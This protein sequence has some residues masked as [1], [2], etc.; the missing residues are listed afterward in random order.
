MRY[1]IY[2]ELGHL[3]AYRLASKNSKTA[4]A[5]VVKFEIGQINN[6]TT[7]WKPYYHFNA[8]NNDEKIVEN[9][10]KIE[11]TL[12]WFIAVTA[13]CTMQS[14]FEQKSFRSCFQIG[15]VGGSDF[16]QI[17]MILYTVKY[18]LSSSIKW[19]D[20]Y[21]LQREF[22]NIVKNHHV[23]N[24][25]EAIVEDI[26]TDITNSD[27]NQ[28]CLENQDLDELI[29]RVDKLITPEIIDDYLYLINK[30]K[31]NLNVEYSE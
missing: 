2:H 4:L 27:E 29:K 30:F 26:E 24:K 5:E 19:K 15:R 13:G 7:T 28:I 8:S 21:G 18:W 23:I 12:A 10:L 16:S 20:I 6:R 25:L 3:F 17:K 14:C 11:R 9:I 22:R 1:M 31:G